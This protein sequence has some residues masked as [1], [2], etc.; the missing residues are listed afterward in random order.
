M[1]QF[2]VAAAIALSLIAIWAVILPLTAQPAPAQ[3]NVTTSAMSRALFLCRG[4]NGLDRACVAMLAK[5]LVLD[6]KDTRTT[7]VNDRFCRVN[8]KCWSAWSATTRP[9]DDPPA[10]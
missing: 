1:R 5:A 9:R 10:H 2:I 4:A 8:S 3:S 6:T 7:Q